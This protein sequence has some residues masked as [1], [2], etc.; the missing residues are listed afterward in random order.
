MGAVELRSA[1][2]VRP[3][4]CTC[5]LPFGPNRRWL[6]NGGLLAGVFGELVGAR[7]TLTLQ[8]GTP[9]T[10]RVAR[11]RERRA[12]AASNGSLRANYTGA[13]IQLSDPTVDEF[14]NTA[15]FTLP[16]PGQFGDS[17][18]N[19]IIGPGARQLNGV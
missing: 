15:A 18:R 6:K 1:P 9:L 17:A 10:A 2:A 8:S 3:A 16:A 7:S 12:R 5:E 13:P 19:M 4:I 14:F 11:R